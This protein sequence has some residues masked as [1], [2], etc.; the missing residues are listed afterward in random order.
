MQDH[1]V[2]VIHGATSILIGIWPVPPYR[3]ASQQRKLSSI[4]DSVSSEDTSGVS[5]VTAVP[6]TDQT[7]PGPPGQTQRG[8]RWSPPEVVRPLPPLMP[9]AVACGL[10][11]AA[12]KLVGLASPVASLALVMALVVTV[13]ASP[14]SRVF[15]RLTGIGVL[16][17][18]AILGGAWH[19][20]RWNGLAE[21][22]L[23]RNVMSGSVPAWLRGVPTSVPEYRPGLNADDEG[24]TRLEIDVTGRNLGQSWQPAT[25]RV[26]VIAGGKRTDIQM[27]IP[28]VATGVIEPIRGPRNPGEA[29]LSA[30]WRAE[31]IRLRLNAD[32]PESIKPDLST[33]R[34]PLTA[35]LGSIRTGCYDRL[36]EGLRPDV[37]ALA[38]ALLLGRYDAIDPAT[39]ADFS[40]TGT[41]H[42]LAISGL[43][44]QA[45]ATLLGLILAVLG[46]RYKP[47]ALVVILAT[48]AYTILVG[49]QPSVVR[50]AVMT[51]TVAVAVLCDYPARSS[52]VLALA[53]LITLAINPAFL[54]NPGC[55]LSF[56]AVGG[57]FWTVPPVANRFGLASPGNSEP[58]PRTPGEYLDRL[59]R[60]L[61]PWPLKKFYQAIRTTKYLFIASVMVWL[62]TLPVIVWAF[63][64]IPLVGSLLNVPLVALSTPT[65][66]T[67]AV[68][69]PAG[70]LADPLK[71]LARS[72]CESVL[73]PQ[74]DA[75]AWGAR[76]PGA[77]IY[78]AGPPTWLVVLY[79]AALGAYLS[80][81]YHAR[82][83]WTRA[84]VGVLMATIVGMALT[85]VLP[86]RPERLE[87][88]VL[89][90]DHGLAV[91]VRAPSGKSL[92]Y[93]CGKMRDPHVGARVIAPALWQR[94]VRWIDTVVL[95]HA[96]ADHYSGLPDLLERFW[97]GEICIPPGFERPTNAGL[98]DLVAFCRN[99]GILVREMTRGQ[100][101]DMGTD[102]SCVVEHPPT[103]YPADRPDNEHSLVLN[104]QSEGRSLLL[105]GDL[106]GSGLTRLLAEPA[107][108]CEAILAP[109]HG[110]RAANPKALYDWAI[111][112]LI[113][114]SQRRPNLGAGELPAWFS[115][116]GRQTLATCD[117]G[118]IRVRWTGGGLMAKAF[119]ENAE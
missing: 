4:P 5:S 53:A 35:Y 69:I 48:I 80:Q 89:E 31:G 94:G 117:Q 26:L 110:S 12:D 49:F 68:L 119:L 50:S 10:G 61:A 65:L 23:A 44:M 20:V 1:W 59:E 7:I 108:H 64:Q 104:L 74:R 81:P 67:V 2:S 18:Y 84:S 97:V 19:H 33:P 38:A 78:A 51:I 3:R 55:Q 54:F 43:H 11:I 112:H 16:L 76:L 91:L 111:P 93:D 87:A 98:A 71:Q 62:V 57:L 95:S 96:D 92:L 113:L 73:S 75:V 22:D 105:T 56:I 99:R 37:A 79:Y 21:N 29:D 60:Q 58:E 15:P 24:T 34:W 102:V 46:V 66:A 72:L 41:T 9:I 103:G 17:I 83:W 30:R 8:T 88:E 47:A 52:N 25:G 14:I 40:R 27:G 70:S 82:L 77:F 86:T 32:G 36:V 107:I 114:V 100:T 118:A 28:V 63:H 115:D 13:L 42:L 90:V 116:N 106:E 6:A 39:F 45:L 109:H 85:V 101:I